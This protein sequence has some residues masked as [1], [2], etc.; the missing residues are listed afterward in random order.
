M[1]RLDNK[2]AIITGG[3]SGIGLA[4]ARLFVAEG[5]RVHLAGLR[6]D[7]LVAATDE[8]GS[9]NVGWS[10]TD[11]TE[12]EQVSGAL[13]QATDRFGPLDVLTY[14]VSPTTTGVASCDSSV[15]SERIHFTRSRS[16]LPVLIWLS[17]L[18]RTTV[19]P[20][21]VTIFVGEVAPRFLMVNVSFCASRRLTVLDCKLESRTRFFS[22]VGLG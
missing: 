14:I 10:V 11:V 7:L 16:M 9:E 3:E 15:P 1:G 18:F 8:L 13:A 2:V 19:V 20:P 5:A 21:P 17:V 6:R 22:P 12:E 4:T